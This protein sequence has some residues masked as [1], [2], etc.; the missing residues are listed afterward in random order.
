MLNTGIF[1]RSALFPRCAKGGTFD[2]A[3]LLQFSDVNRDGKFYAL[4]LASRFLLKNDEGAHGYGRR[5]AAAANNGI[6][7][8]TGSEPS[9]ENKVHYVGFYDL[10]YGALKRIELEYYKSGLV[11][12]A[13]HGET[14]HFQVEWHLSSAA[15]TLNVKEKVL[16]KDRSAARTMISFL[17]K[18][19]I[20]EE[21]IPAELEAFELPTLPR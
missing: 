21:N 18:G 7:A 11:R 4:S 8:R 19:P 15:A 20:K 10:E 2:E 1:C 9:P 16:R 14:A 3:A 5:T 6:L 13:E 12:K 17:L